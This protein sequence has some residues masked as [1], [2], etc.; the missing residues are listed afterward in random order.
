MMSGAYGLAFDSARPLIASRNGIV[1]ASNTL[2]S[3]VGARILERGGN[4][5]DAA[6]AS[7]AV[8]GFVQPFSC[9]IGGDLFAIV[10]EP[11]PSCRI[12]GLNASGWAPRELTLK[13]LR[14]SGATGPRIS[15]T[16]A[17]A[18]TVPGCVA[19]WDAL[20]KRFGSMSFAQVSI[21]PLCCFASFSVAGNSC[22]FA[23][24][25]P[26]HLP[27]AWRLLHGCRCCSQHHQPGLTTAARLQRNICG[28]RNTASHRRHVPEH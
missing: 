7:N 28:L 3:A 14:E 12:H 27:G 5:V 22:S 4:A 23:V 2:A 9:G 10:Q 16:S 25:G 8:T 19:G 13:A 26:G 15:S 1:A 17:H 21:W 24:A 20:R 11:P 18:V 6:I